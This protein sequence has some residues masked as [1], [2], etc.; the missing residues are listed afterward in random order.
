MKSNHLNVCKASNDYRPIIHGFNN[1]RVPFRVTPNPN[2]SAH[3]SQRL[4][5]QPTKFST[6]NAQ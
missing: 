5:L 6:T 4:P 3:I 2:V 1:P